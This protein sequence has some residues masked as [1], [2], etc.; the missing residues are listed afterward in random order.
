MVGM[1]VYELREEKEKKQRAKIRTQG[2]GTP[3]VREEYKLLL[4]G[5][6]RERGRREGEI[7]FFFFFF[8]IK[9]I[10]GKVG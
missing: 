6:G 4:E 8:S 7:F 2:L 1:K 10:K 5:A 9:R 3:N